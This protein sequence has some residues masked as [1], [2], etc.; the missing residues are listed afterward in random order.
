MVADFQEAGTV[1]VNASRSRCASSALRFDIGFILDGCPSQNSG[2]RCSQHLASASN[3][4]RNGRQGHPSIGALMTDERL[5]LRSFRMRLLNHRRGFHHVAKA[6]RIIRCKTAPSTVCPVSGIG[7][8]DTS[9]FFNNI[10]R[11]LPKKGLRATN[12]GF[13]TQH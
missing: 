8:P 13:T 11:R 10:A 7:G 1:A 5:K 12:N 4:V 3:R 2:R 9:H 6:T